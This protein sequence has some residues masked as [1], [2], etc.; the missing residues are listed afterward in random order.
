MPYFMRDT[1]DTLQYGYL[2]IWIPYNKDILQYGY[3]AIWRPCNMDTLQYRYLA[4]WR[5]CNLDTLQYGYITITIPCNMD[6][7]QYGDHAMFRTES[8]GLPRGTEIERNTRFWFP[9]LM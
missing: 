4:I 5:P 8:E 6:T 9:F 3:L 2:A 7:L 1:I